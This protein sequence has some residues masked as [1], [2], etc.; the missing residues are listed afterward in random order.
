MGVYWRDGERVDAFRWTG[1]ADQEEDPAWAAQAA[2]SGA[3]RYLNSG[4]SHVTIVAETA[5]GETMARPGDWLIRNADG[6]LDVA[7]DIVF[8]RRY[9]PSPAYATLRLC[10]GGS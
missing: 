3:L 2:R 5:E 6:A 1:G 10:S 9:S 8:R 7:T 4:T